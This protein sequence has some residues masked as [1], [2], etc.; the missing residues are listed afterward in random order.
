MA[1][2]YPQNATG[3]NYITYP[4]GPTAAGL[5]LT[6]NASANTKGVYNEFIASTPFTANFL[7]VTI[8]G[9]NV[10]RR[11]LV[12]IATGGAGA[13]VVLFPNLL[14]DGSGGAAGNTG[15]AIH[16]FPV[17]IPSGTRIAGRVQS[18]TGGAVVTLTVTLIA[19]GGMVG[20]TTFVNYGS[21]TGTSGGVAVD[22]GGVANT[23]GAYSEITASTSGVIQWMLI[24]ATTGANAAPAAANFAVDIATGGAGTEVVLVPDLRTNTTTQMSPNPA[25]WS[26][27]TYIP[28]STRI[29][30]RMSSGITDATDRVLQFAIIAATAPAEDGGGSGLTWAPLSVLAGAGLSMVRAVA[31]GSSPLSS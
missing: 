26:L 15:A 21:N 19:A 3:L 11:Y 17:A 16:V 10:A 5:T 23:K 29:A 2:I 20:A 22:P 28:A 24:M 30:I 1:F 4:V 14:V 8:T 25:S 31:S 12:D 27:L 9:M 13:E 7:I 6:A 18:S